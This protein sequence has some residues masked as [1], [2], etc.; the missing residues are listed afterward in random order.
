VR[1]SVCCTA[2]LSVCSL[3]QAKFPI[4]Y[5]DLGSTTKLQH[6]CRDQGWITEADGQDYPSRESGSGFER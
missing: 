1:R 3:R 4:I 2:S 5:P 6:I